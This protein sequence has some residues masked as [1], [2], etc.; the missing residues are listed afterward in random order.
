LVRS[1]D[2]K[3]NRDTLLDVL[4]RAISSGEL[5]A[6]VHDRPVARLERSTLVEV[7][8]KTLGDLATNALLVG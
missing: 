6:H 5:K 3:H 8:D 1:L 7:L 4:D 2:G